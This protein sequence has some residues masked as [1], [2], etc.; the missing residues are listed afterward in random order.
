MGLKIKLPNLIDANT[1]KRI[2]VHVPDEQVGSALLKMAEAS[3]AGKRAAEELSKM[4]RRIN[5]KRE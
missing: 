2:E 3:N 1:G 4:T 5:K